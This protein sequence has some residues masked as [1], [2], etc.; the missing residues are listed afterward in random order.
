MRTTKRKRELQI[1]RIC[2]GFTEGPVRG[3]GR[4]ALPPS[5]LSSDS[6]GARLTPADLLTL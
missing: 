2:R 6:F 3:P 1:M 4:P 5:A